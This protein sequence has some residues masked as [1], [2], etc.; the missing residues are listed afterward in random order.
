MSRVAAAPPSFDNACGVWFHIAPTSGSSAEAP[1]PLPSGCDGPR[2][3]VAPRC[4]AGSEP[5]GGPVGWPVGPAEP[6]LAVSLRSITMIS[7]SNPSILDRSSVFIS[8]EKRRRISSLSRRRRFRQPTKFEQ[9]DP[10]PGKLAVEGCG[11]VV[12]P[13]DERSLEAGGPRPDRS[14]EPSRSNTTIAR[15]GRRCGS[16]IARAERAGR[17]GSSSESRPLPARP[18]ASPS[19]RSRSVGQPAA[20]PAAATGSSAVARSDGG[21][22][23]RIRHRDVAVRLRR[24]GGRHERQDP[25][26]PIEVDRQSES[27][28]T[29]AGRRLR[30]RQVAATCRD[31]RAS[32]SASA[33]PP[34]PRDRANRASLRCAAGRRRC[35][36]RPQGARK[37][38][39]AWR[40]WLALTTGSSTPSRDR[41]SAWRCGARRARRNHSRVCATGCGAEPKPP[42][43]GRRIVVDAPAPE[44][45]GN[46]LASTSRRV[47]SHPILP[48]AKSRSSSTSRTI[49]RIHPHRRLV[50]E[51]NRR[52][53]RTSSA[54]RRCNRERY[55]AITRI[56]L[57]RERRRDLLR[58]RADRCR[59]AA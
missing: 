59:R 40:P 45:A 27:P 32:R 21:S 11:A 14:P 34:G 10:R 16:A 29:S 55:A 26:Q 48:R 18:F 13:I 20:R 46:A 36:P 2:H 25:S 8:P 43:P 47:T 50:L 3:G 58:G 53:A 22:D 6:R 17:D 51:R 35:R 12:L 42:V 52:A 19:M 39:W 38:R 30:R 5:P 56:A 57:A 7:G 44:P 24:G 4:P 37:W 9:L 15:R 33:A 1:R 49:A 23:V 41:R 54:K 28:R 31:A